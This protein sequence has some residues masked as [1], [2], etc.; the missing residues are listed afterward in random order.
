MRIED[1]T[2]II[3]DNEL[4]I[5]DYEINIDSQYIEPID[6]NINVITVQNISTL[7]FEQEKRLCNILLKI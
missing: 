4:T 2:T 3:D 5:E 7:P 1:N 6:N